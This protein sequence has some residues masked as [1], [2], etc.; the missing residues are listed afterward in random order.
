M[1]AIIYGRPG[2]GF[3][4]RAKELC[5]KK[6][7]PFEYFIVGEDIQKEKLEEMVGNSIRSVPQIFLVSDGMTEYVGGFGELEARI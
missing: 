1:K 4:N 6:G 7:I 2:C 5:Q 3:C